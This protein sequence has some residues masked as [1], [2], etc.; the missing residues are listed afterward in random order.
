MLKGVYGKFVCAIVLGFEPWE[1]SLTW[2][3]ASK[4]YC[5]WVKR[6][7]HSTFTSVLPLLVV[8]WGVSTERTSWPILHITEHM[9]AWWFS[10]TDSGFHVT[11]C[12]QF[13]LQVGKKS[14]V[15]GI[16]D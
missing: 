12:L 4:H 2:P 16:D 5:G 8:G 9:R 14:I 1:E 7:R 6:R 3:A 10:T 13:L 11:H 15:C